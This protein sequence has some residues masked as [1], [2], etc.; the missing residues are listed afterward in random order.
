MSIFESI[1]SSVYQRNF[2]DVSGV[3]FFYTYEDV[4]Y[5]HG[6]YT[7]KMYNPNAN[8]PFC[9]LASRTTLYVCIGQHIRREMKLYE[10]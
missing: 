1:C 5:N 3:I 9:P 6:S 7:I 4:A 8:I 10:T 2:T